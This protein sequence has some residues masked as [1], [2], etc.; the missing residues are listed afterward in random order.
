M[1][2][3]GPQSSLSPEA[4]NTAALGLWMA[5]WWAT[6]ATPVGV[7]AFIPL[8]FFPL[9]GITTLHKAAAPYANPILYLYMGGFLIA[10]AMQRWD[11]H[12]RIAL[13]LLTF[14]GT[15][16]RSLVGGF[17]VTAALLSM[18]MTNTSTT[19]M[20]LPIVI[21]VISV[22]AVTV[23]E[24]GDD[25]RSNFEICLLLGTAFGATIGGVA[26]LVG[27][28]PNAFLAAFLTENYGIEISFARW[29]LVGVP[30]T[31]IL[32]PICWLVL[33]RLIY[34]I[35]FATSSET[36]N[37]LQS[38]RADL[39]PA[40]S[41]EWR[42]GIVFACVVI[43][44]MTRP[45]LSKVLPVEGLSDPGIVMIAAFVLFLMPSGK[46]NSARMLTWKETRDL[47][48]AILI[49]FGGGLSLAAAVSETGL[50]HWL[51]ASLVPLGA[52]GIGAIVV[53]AVVLVIF[54]TE[55]TSNLATTATL[56]PVLAA[57]ALEL[58]VDPVVLTVPVALAASCAFMLPVATP[59]N[60]IV[61]G[62]GR[63]T[64]PQMAKAGFVM[65]MV[66]IILLSLVALF[67]APMVLSD[68][69]PPRD[70]PFAVI[71][72]GGTI[73]N[74]DGSDGQVAD[75]GIAGDRIAAIGD[76]SARDADLRLDVTGMA[77]TP[78]FIDI[79]SHAVRSSKENSGIFLW[80]NAENYIRQGVTTAIGGP[81]GS[82]WY[83]LTEL[84]AMLE[85]TPSSVNFGTFIGHN[86][87][88]TLAMGRAN[89]A[90]TEEELKEMSD[91]VDTAM[92]DGAFGLSSGLKYIPGAYSKTDEVVELARVAGNRGGIYIT[93]MRE[94]GTGL[95]ESVRETIRIGEQGG[96]PAQVTH[97]KAMGM[98]AWGKSAETLALIDAAN[99]RGLD[100]S[101]D[102][103]PYTA[104]STGIDVLFPAWS[105][106]GEKE[107]RL[108]RLQDPAVRAEIKA[109][110]I[111]N[112]I[113]DR[114]GND[115]SR[116]AIANCTWD[117]ELNGKN[118]A[119]I[120]Q[121]RGADISIGKAAELAMELEEKGGCSAVYH[122]MSE[123]DVIRIMQHGKTMVASDGG[124]HMPA[125]D[126]PHPRN[127][128]SFSRV[129]GKYV[130][131]DGV[132]G[133][134]EAIHK[135]SRMPA[136][137]IGLADRG[138]IEVGA[139][140]DIAVLDPA[141]VIDRATFKNPHQ[142]SEGV[143]H[144]FVNGQAALIDGEMTGVRP[145]RV[146]RSGR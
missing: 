52:L 61:Y 132:L 14:S 115:P 87:V 140:A 56:L 78:G 100:I 94:E 22:I 8:I 46:R 92:L 125:E 65:N 60:A 86:T 4:W 109:G 38:M 39:G 79:H 141:T 96:L 112:I 17:M 99:A 108:A 27:T 70:E 32:L 138:R 102:Q 142:L 88:R 139:M 119:E 25:E 84:F 26:T 34:P 73:Y 64:I 57:L 16:G 89:R 53:G 101:S 41:A 36:R 128:G 91:M 21:S 48:W 130:R 105:L 28:P 43:G 127:Y 20:L 133:F 98:R 71:L 35:S 42:I 104:S 122:A 83:P 74:G 124:I 2:I 110:I 44:W 9:L 118:L 117:Q 81:D 7:T 24:I 11:L 55:L 77:V 146:L 85:E 40:S 134:S 49:L 106:A 136:D 19:M 63:I 95:V 59:P 145:G 15:N 131:E 54:L 113:N 6:E 80:P 58:G 12:K 62:S 126:R 135:M 114:G 76:L 97:H 129:L 143:L 90:P 10:L 30:V 18:W 68:E 3:I 45:W 120:L 107:V 137:R 50:A 1:L 75:L 31:I 37:L 121:E 69:T 103:Y 23:K 66:G 67:L 5:V 116:V 72:Q 144:V 51:G 93:H 33:V 111:D 29:M 13:A 47:P 82:S 123:E